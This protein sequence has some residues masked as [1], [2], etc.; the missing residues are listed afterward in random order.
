MKVNQ[1]SGVIREVQS[2][3]LESDFLLGYIKEKEAVTKLYSEVI[4]DVIGALD[5]RRIN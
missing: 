1:T 5:F 3:C 4:T 2:I